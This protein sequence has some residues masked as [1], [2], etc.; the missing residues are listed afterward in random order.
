MITI[1]MWSQNNVMGQSQ[2]STVLSSI[3]PAEVLA[4]A[5]SHYQ[6]AYQ[7]AVYA[8]A[9]TY[10][11]Q[12]YVP[13]DVTSV[14]VR[15]RNMEF[16][17]GG[18]GVDISGV[19]IGIGKSDTAFGYVGSPVT[20][21]GVTVPG[22]T[23]YVSPW[24]AVT[25]GS[26]SRIVVAYTVPAGSTVYGTNGSI[27]WAKN[28]SGTAAVNPIPAGSPSSITNLPYYLCLEYYTYKRRVVVLGDSIVAGY[29]QY[30]DRPSLGSSFAYGLGL[31]HNWGVDAFGIPA[32]RLQTYAN[33]SNTW[34]LSTQDFSGAYVVVEAGVNDL[35]AQTFAQYQ[36]NI[37]SLVSLLQAAG[38]KKIIWHT[39]MPQTTYPFDSL[40]QQVN[41]Y[42]LAGVSGID[43]VFDA[44]TLMQNPA[45]HAQ[46]L[47]AYDSGDGIH[48]ST[49]GAA[50]LELGLYNVLA[51]IP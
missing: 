10:V 28:V 16:A 8:T 46:L 5:S 37:A 45:N 26:D 21:T 2:N 39:I 35:P 31:D 9:Q 48:L 40:R 29:N 24:T 6:V 12:P 30:F 38:T 14:R 42:L 25:S 15:M 27:Y 50:A 1:R 13:S 41:A 11:V 7:S 47:P 36:A 32:T 33:P 23:D 43:V 49:V 18:A 20:Y 22:A 4:L 19:S 51:G 17:G 3:T 34:M 44:A